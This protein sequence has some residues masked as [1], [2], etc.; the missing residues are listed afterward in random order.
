MPRPLPLHPRPAVQAEAFL[1][2][3]G[4]LVAHLPRALDPIAEIHMRQAEA[5]RLLDMVENDVTAERAARHMR[6]VERIDERQ[7]VGEAVGE[8]HAEERTRGLAV[9]GA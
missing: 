9:A 8:T 6:I 1:R 4:G 5:A 7:A 3:V 2:Q